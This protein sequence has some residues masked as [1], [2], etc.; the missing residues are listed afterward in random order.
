MY[1]SQLTVS[2]YHLIMPYVI[3]YLFQ[4]ISRVYVCVSKVIQQ[5]KN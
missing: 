3:D 1:K 2:H 5:Q 4:L